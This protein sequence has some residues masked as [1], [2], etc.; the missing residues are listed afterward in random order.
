[1]YSLSP[2]SN[3]Q[4]KKK[5]LVLQSLKYLSI[6]ACSSCWS[7]SSSWRSHQPGKGP[8][9]SSRTSPLRVWSSSLKP[10]P[11]LLSLKGKESQEIPRNTG[12]CWRSP[13]LACSAF[14]PGFCRSSP[15]AQ[16]RGISAPF[17]PCSGFPPT[18]KF[19]FV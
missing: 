18:A 2:G 15:A 8:P 11:I 4:P 7:R 19:H 10:H 6:C 13:A 17:T 12:S 14:I 1:M 5:L 16:P 9:S 3:Y